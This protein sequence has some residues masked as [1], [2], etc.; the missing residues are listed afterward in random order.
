MQLKTNIEPLDP[1][2]CTA[3]YSRG[4]KYAE[5]WLSKGGPLKADA[6]DN[7]AEDRANG[8]CDRLVR[9]RNARATVPQQQ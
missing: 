3:G 7:W 8:F 5:W 2:S 9:E 6:P 1:G 4:W